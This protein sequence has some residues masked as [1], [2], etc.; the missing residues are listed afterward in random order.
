MRQKK[1]LLLVM[2]ILLVLVLTGCNSD[3]PENKIG[4]NPDQQLTANNS[5]QEDND[6]ENNVEKDTTEPAGEHESGF[7]GKIYSIALDAIMPVEDSLNE[8]MTYIAVDTNTLDD[9]TDEDI[10]NIINDLTKYNVEVIEA[11]FDTLKS[12][13]MVK[14]GASLDGVLL[15]ISSVKII[16]E[17]KIEIIGSKY[18]SGT[19]AIGVKCVLI[20]AAGEWIIGSSEIIWVS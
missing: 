6:S 11:S 13:D 19:A 2:S 9:A 20:N 14:D 4:L 1:I 5:D 10:A 17:D 12:E 7:F 8:N 15:K 3:N 18:R 16:S